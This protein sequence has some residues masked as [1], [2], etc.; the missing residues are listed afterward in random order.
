MLFAQ[1]KNLAQLI[2]LI[3]PPNIGFYH[4]LRRTESI[5]KWSHVEKMTSGY[6][7]PL[8]QVILDPILSRKKIIE[9]L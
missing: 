9:N 1:L 3:R 2:V 7:I 5:T 8:I 6:R 4:L